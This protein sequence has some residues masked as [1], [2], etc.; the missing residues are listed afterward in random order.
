MRGIEQKCS[1]PDTKPVTMA[2]NRKKKET[3]IEDGNLEELKIKLL[4]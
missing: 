1:S 4:Q 2:S 3:R